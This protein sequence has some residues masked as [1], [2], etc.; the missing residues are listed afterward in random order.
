LITDYCGKFNDWTGN[1]AALERSKLMDWKEIKELSEHNIE[2]AAHSR[3]HAD[4]TRIP[5]QE[6]KREM[7][8]SKFVI[9][10][11]LGVS[12]TNF[13]YPYGVYNTQIE[14][15]AREHF[16]SA[17]STRLGKVKIGDNP[18]TLKRLDTYYLSNEKIFSSI[19][20]AS[21]DWYMNFRQW[22]RDLRT[23]CYSK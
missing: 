19:F 11:K 10:N 2:F 8:E 9:E 18:F 7:T 12:A 1:L 16:K 21:F 4:L 15:L 23:K 6:A 14:E 22:M 20:S 3:T 13:A 5:V 17:C